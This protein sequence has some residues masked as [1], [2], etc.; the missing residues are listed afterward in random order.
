MS[1]QNK[2][3]SVDIEDIDKKKNESRD[4]I[5]EN[6][7]KYQVKHRIVRIVIFTIV[8]IFIMVFVGSKIAY[9]YTD[10][11]YDSKQQP[12]NDFDFYTTSGINDDGFFANAEE[13]V[14]ETAKDN[15]ITYLIFKKISPY[16]E[17]LEKIDLLIVEI[18]G[19]FGVLSG[20]SISKHAGVSF[21]VAYN[22]TV[23]YDRENEE[24]ISEEIG[25]FKIEEINIGIENV[26]NVEFE[27]CYPEISMYDHLYDSHYVLCYEPDLTVKEA[28]EKYDVAYNVKSNN[29]GND[30]I[31]DGIKYG[32]SIKF[33]ELD[34]KLYFDETDGATVNTLVHFKVTLNG[35]D[36]HTIDF[37][38]EISNSIN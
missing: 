15:D 26:S 21:E 23:I 27:F 19:K 8:I 25:D 1:E 13:G 30:G 5:N 36:F 28:T 3:N 18:G 9:R 24:V 16:G 2:N 12:F 7:R 34:Y 31:I 10:L 32:K 37:A 22:Y 17:N 29:V 33:G 4:A 20:E 14:F 38:K 35:E 11:K 6:Y